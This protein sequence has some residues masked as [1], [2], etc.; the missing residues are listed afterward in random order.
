VPVPAGRLKLTEQGETISFKYGLR[1]LAR[2]NLEA[3][4]A[5]TLL[6]SVMPAAETSS[7]YIELMTSMATVAEEHWRLLVYQTP[8]F[9]GFL[10]AFTPI[11]ELA[12]INVGSRPARREPD[13]QRYLQSLRAIPWVF[14]WTQNRTLLPAW[15]GCGSALAEHTGSVKSLQVLQGMY[16][17]WPFFQTMIDNLEMTLA[18]SSMAIARAYLQ[19]TSHVPDAGVIWERIETEYARTVDAVLQVR[20]TTVLLEHKPVLK[21][22]IE[23][24]NPYVDPMNFV[25]VALLS[26][27]RQT[28]NE[29]ERTEVG[30]A[31]AR[32]I[33]GI[34]AALRNTG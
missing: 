25:Q 4:T 32:S 15:Y 3:A 34:A 23:L 5:A 31:L 10:R 17:D 33:A 12:L 19:L 28:E 6:S 22:S 18:K 21:R 26:A 16:E 9:V 11:D 8:S 27:Y 1:G 7:D 30:R 20:G 24:R 13:E 2:R 14:S 29:A